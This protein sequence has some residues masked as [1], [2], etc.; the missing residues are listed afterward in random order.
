MDG[1]REKNEQRDD[2]IILY[3]KNKWGKNN[4]VKQER[5]STPW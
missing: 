1:C 5:K 4:I 2:V 3:L